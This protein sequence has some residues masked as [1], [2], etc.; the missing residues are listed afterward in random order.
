MYRKSYKDSLFTKSLFL[1]SPKNLSKVPILNRVVHALTSATLHAAEYVR[2]NIAEYVRLNM[3]G[4]RATT[5]DS[6]SLRMG[7]KNEVMNTTL[8]TPNGRHVTVV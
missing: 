1:I 5:L 8:K 3:L 4:V 6:E 7:L 2:L